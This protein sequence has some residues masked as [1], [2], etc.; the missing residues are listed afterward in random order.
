MKALVNH[1]AVRRVARGVSGHLLTGLIAICLSSSSA[2]AL[3]DEKVPPEESRIAG[4]PSDL[5]ILYEDGLVHM[6]VKD[7][8]LR[9]VLEELCLKAGVELTIESGLQGRLTVK[10]NGIPLEKA[11]EKICG[12]RAVV[13]DYLPHDKAFKVKA[14]KVFASSTAEQPADSLGRPL[15]VPGEILIK[16]KDEINKEALADFHKTLGA[17]VLDRLKRL[18]LERLALP[19]HVSEE[20]AVSI[21]TASGVVEYAERHVLRYPQT[22]PNDPYFPEQWA[23]PKIQAPAAWEV[24]RGSPEIIIAVIDTGIDL[25]HPDLAGNIWINQAELNGVSGE[26]DDGNGY[27]DDIYGWDFGGDIYGAENNDPSDQSGH[28]THIAGIIGAKGDNGIGV[29]G[30]SWDTRIMA[31]K[32]QADGRFDMDNWAILKALDYAVGN[33]ARVVNC[34][35][36]GESY[37]RPEYDAYQDL[38]NSGI[39]AVCA[40]GNEGLDLDAD[41]KNY[42]ASYD[43]DNIIAVTGSDRYDNLAPSSNYGV[44]N[45]DL[46]APAYYIYSTIPTAGVDYIDASVT[47]ILDSFNIPYPA[48]SLEYAGITAQEGITATAY[49]CGLGG[50]SS[51]F[52][53]EVN[54]GIAL[55]ERGGDIFFST[56]AANAQEAG[57]VGVIIYNNEEEGAFDNWTLQAPGGWIPVVGISR[58]H[59]EEL[60]ML[61]P[62]TLTI[63][64]SF[65]DDPVHYSTMQGTSM[66]A[67]HVSGLA[68]LLLSAD[69]HVTYTELKSAILKGV[70]KIPDLEDKLGSGGRLNA[71]R[72]LCFLGAAPEESCCFMWEPGLEHAVTALKILSGLTPDLP[73]CPLDMDHDGIT[74]LHDLLVI[75]QSVAGLRD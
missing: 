57:A 39:L 21:Y 6:D 67:P 11:L 45:V 43:L 1:S 42:P 75:L 4:K 28:G 52:P 62:V 44:E 72:S 30:I 41:T 32:V 53:Q 54:G 2:F 61:A 8:D 26:D 13:Y 38:R 66:A 40:A 47:A 51:D 3:P 7:A 34:S 22:I 68:G 36:G 35:F 14:L 56:K 29:A 25:L 31:L 19:L 20:D 70:D 49:F 74:S 18:R 46:M 12:N 60:K 63:V 16:L 37:S 50:D 58:E 33:G 23:L 71:I 9:R 17:T 55:I 73:P 10:I 64:N 27:I 15:Y 69:P 59:G 5:L 24:T 48:A 65:N